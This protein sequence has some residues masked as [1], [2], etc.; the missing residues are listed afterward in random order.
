MEL[1]DLAH[2]ASAW[3]RQ[4]H[5]E[6]DARQLLLRLSAALRLAVDRTSVANA[7]D[8]AQD[9]LESWPNTARYHDLAGIWHSRY[10]HTSDS[11]E[12]RTLDAQR[13]VTIGQQRNRA[14]VESLPHSL[15]SQP[16]MQL[17]VDGAIA[18]GVWHEKT[19][20][21]GNYKGAT[22]HGAI[23]L[24][25][26]PRGRH[27]TGR[28]LGFDSQYQIGVGDSELTWAE[29]SLSKVAQRRYH[30]KL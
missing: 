28:W 23:Q 17:S 10:Q 8:P 9:A 21:V 24:I 6:P 25:I 30:L 19:S 1:A 26:D 12:N 13:Y 22:Y 20:P 2:I 18:T 14:I 7:L 16:T 5:A 4:V 3:V 27:M 11:L 29:G 15:D